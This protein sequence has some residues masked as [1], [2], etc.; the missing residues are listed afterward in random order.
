[1]FFLNSNFEI[2]QP[3]SN[4]YENLYINEVVI[5]ESVSA[6]GY[7]ILELLKNKFT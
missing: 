2:F 4:D 7:M 1:M 6:Q 5:I 3:N